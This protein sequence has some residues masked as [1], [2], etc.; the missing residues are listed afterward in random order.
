LRKV[1]DYSTWGIPSLEVVKDLMARRGMLA[2]NR[3]LTEE[4][5]KENGTKGLAPKSAICYSA[6]I[7]NFY[8]KHNLRLNVA[9][10]KEFEGA[11]K[12]ENESEKMTAEQIRDLRSRA[13][14]CAE[15]L[16]GWFTGV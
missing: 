9:L 15:L 1:K 6:A 5:V 13:I 3:K 16:A 12:G 14:L 7:L 11:T 10:T 4:Y 2:G 8:R